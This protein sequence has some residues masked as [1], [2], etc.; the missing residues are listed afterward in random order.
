[1]S[2]PSPP[3][4]FSSKKTWFIT[5]CST[6]LGRELVLA[7]L[8]HGDNVVATA[9]NVAKIA[10]LEQRGAFLLPFDVTSSDEVLEAAVAQAVEKFGSIDI[11]VNNAGYVLIGAIEECSAEE[12]LQQFNTNVFGI[13]NVCRAVLPYM[14][15]QKS[16]VVANI[17]S[18]GGWKGFPGSGLYCASKFAVACISESLRAEV[19]HLGIDVTVIEPGYF[20]TSLLGAGSFSAKKH[21][22]DLDPVTAPAK[23]LLA[24]VNGKQSGDPVKGA[25]VIVEAL[26]KSG[27]CAG[28]VL[29]A[30]LVLGKD[31]VAFETSVLELRQQELSEWSDIAAST[32]CDDVQ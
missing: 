17:G 23:A 18:I 15:K 28:R 2:T 10:D 26:T 6:G 25:K 16:G 31:A 3:A 11:L 21:I 5:G 22:A 27:R 24:S 4:S 1:M 13:L 30:R 32:D 7:A 19:S 20:R 14:R 29:P 12:A 9:R 8:A